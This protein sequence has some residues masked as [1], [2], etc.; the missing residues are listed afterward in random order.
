M[1]LRFIFLLEKWVHP[2]GVASRTGTPRCRSAGSNRRV[3]RH[4]PLSPCSTSPKSSPTRS[5]V[6]FSRVC[7]VVPRFALFRP[8]STKS[9][10]IRSA[11]VVPHWLDRARILPVPFSNP[12]SSCFPAASCPETLRTTRLLVALRLDK[13]TPHVGTGHCRARAHGTCP[14]S[15]ACPV[16]GLRGP[17]LAS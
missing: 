15:G 17:M 5:Q 10:R 13:R 3:R 8:D 7:A 11:R 2:L 14:V 6:T 9:F 1:L 16:C 12:E 4:H